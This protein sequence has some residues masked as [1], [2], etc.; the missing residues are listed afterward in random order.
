MG[1]GRLE[2]AAGALEEAVRLRRNYTP[3]HYYLANV[4]RKL[5][6][7]DEAK[8]EFGEVTR[9]KEEESKPVPKLSYHRGGSMDR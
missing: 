8:R 7:E 5:G 3:A 1:G 6:R 2:E 4:Y 9:L